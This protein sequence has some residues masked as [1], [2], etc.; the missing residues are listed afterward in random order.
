M[1]KRYLGIIC[2]LYSGIILYV[3][4]FDKMKNFLA[5]Q[6]QI[7]LKLA[8]IPLLIMGIILCVNDKVHYKFKISDIVLLLPIVM[9][10]LAGDGRLTT[11]FAKNRMTSFANSGTTESTKKEDEEVIVVKPDLDLETIDDELDEVTNENYDFTNTYFDITDT[12]YDTL[13][14]YI[15]FAE[16]ATKFTGQTIRVRGFTVTNE[17]YLSDGYFAIGKYGI[18]CCVADAGFVGFIA[19]YDTSKVKNNTW[20]EIEGVLE[21]GIYNQNQQMM[22]IRVINIKEIVSKNEEQYVYPCYSYEDTMCT[23]LHKYNLEY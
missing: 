1:K 19:K 22:A 12:M 7:Y 14:N 6:M 5:P 21:P 4:L 20:Y 2:L 8:L 17:S 23:E 16:K 15:T 13:A 10:I 18:S 9:L 3:W 11:T